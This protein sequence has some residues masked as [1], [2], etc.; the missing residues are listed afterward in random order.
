MNISAYLNTVAK[1]FQ[2]ALRS[3]LQEFPG[4][5]LA[6]VL[7]LPDLLAHGGDLLREPADVLLLPPHDL[8]VQL[9]QPAQEKLLPLLQELVQLL[10][11]GP[12]PLPLGVHPLLQ[13]ERTRGAGAGMGERNASGVDRRGDL[14]LPEIPG[15]SQSLGIIER[16]FFFFFCRF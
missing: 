2:R 16:I 14:S 7:Q 12:D 4:W 1:G 3:H 15:F 9:C 8:P 13:R 11:P 5:L 6:L 10:D